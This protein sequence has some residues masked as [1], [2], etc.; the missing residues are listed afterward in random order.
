MLSSLSVNQSALLAMSES[1]NPVPAPTDTK[2]KGFEEPDIL[3]CTLPIHTE[4][5]QIDQDHCETEVDIYLGDA[6]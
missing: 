1:R 6:G 2:N 3:N 5:Q 4:R